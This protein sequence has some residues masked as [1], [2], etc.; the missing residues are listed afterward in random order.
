MNKDDL[1]SIFRNLGA[2]DPE[3]WA[4]SEVSENIPQLARF[5]FLKGA[6][7]RIVRDDD[8]QW[9]DDVLQNVP[10]ESN[11]PYAGAAHAVRQMLDAGVSKL[12]IA[13]L[14]RATQAEFLFDL[15]YMLDDSSSVDGNDDY[16]DWSFVE[17]DADGNPGR[18]IN[19]LHESV[20]ATDPTGR[21]VRPHP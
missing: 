21:E 7:Q 14:V 5:M 4:D 9:I 12:A 13:Q 20:L 17:L 8:T 19:G 3:S 15:C 1:T 18:P 2:G 16:V 10:A 11:D 6:W